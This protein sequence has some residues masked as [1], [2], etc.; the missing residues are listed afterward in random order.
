MKQYNL[1][2]LS[3]L[4]FF[5]SPLLHA[6]EKVNLLT[7][8]QMYIGQNATLYISGDFQAESNT[9]IAH[10]GKTILEGD[11]INN[12]T[13]GQ[14]FNERSGTFEFKGKKPQVI[15][16]LVSQSTYYTEFPNTVI[17]NNQ[18]TTPD[19]VK[20]TID[21]LVGIS[22]KNLT[23]TRGR[24]ILDS[25]IS[26]TAGVR[27]T[28][29]AHLY[30]EDDKGI[31]YNRVPA[32]KQDKGI[33][34]VNLALG[35]NYKDG[36]LVGFTPP[37]NKIY[38]DY[39]F[40]N[41]LSIPKKTGLFNGKDLWV[42]NPKTALPAGTG[43]VLGQGL[44]P[45]GDPYYTDPAN[46]RPGYENADYR[47]VVK[48]KFSFARDF[49]PSFLE[50]VNNDHA[51]TDEFTGEELN[52]KD[53]TVDNIGDGFNHIGNPFTVPL[54][55]SAFVT[56]TDLGK[57]GF[58]RSEVAP[59]FYVL[60]NGTGKRE[61]NKRDFS[62]TTSYL[63]GQGTGGT[64]PDPPYGRSSL[65]APMQMFVIKR[66]S[67]SK[68]SMTIPQSKRTR[69]N[70]PFLRSG[71]T[72][73]V[74]DELLIETKDMQTGGFDRLCVVFRNGATLKANDL[75]D[76][77]KLFNRTG[78]VNQ[79]YTRSEDNMKLTTNV[80]SPSTQRLAMYFEPSIERQE[81]QLRVERINSLVS[82]N[83]VILEDKKTGAKTDLLRTP[84]YTFVSSPY[85]KTDR[86]ILHFASSPVGIDNIQTSSPAVNAYYDAGSI[87]IQGLQDE[88]NGR[89]VS[90]YDVQGQ[91]IHRQEIAGTTPCRISK[92]LNKG[93]YILKIAGKEHII[94]LPVM[95]K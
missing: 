85:D 24:L 86:F 49:G 9:Q 48:E 74:V 71:E 67:G 47:D 78:G 35:D 42:L 75:Y 10:I 44:V 32:N 11:F 33:I 95:S 16:G 88:D 56:G 73:T 72:N 91:L 14:I 77:E 60:A 92:S 41:F 59:A 76:A 31:S 55:V 69:A 29:I 62:F 3:G 25:K 87:Y 89:I 18:A 21:P 82:V 1:F 17:I 19:S 53:V 36:H 46:R 52:I 93:I 38:A 22:V 37:F 61:A 57:W 15:K 51:I 27:E 80:I 70:T 50:Y 8:G 54:D 94:K 81:V 45:H 28:H 84:S 6:Q 79:I 13:S 12:A 65:I 43:Y 58:E 63:V 40:F 83:S 30:A 26:S 90:I 23:L 34:Q 2:L 5:L 39:F 64:L 20:V 4:M 66:I 68:T 7:K